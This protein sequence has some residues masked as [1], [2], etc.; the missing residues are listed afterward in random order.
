MDVLEDWVCSLTQTD[1]VRF[2]ELNPSLRG[3]VDAARL[4]TFFTNYICREDTQFKD[5]SKTFA[6]IATDLETGREIWFT[7]GLVLNAV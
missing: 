7:K 5:L 2:F 3:F 4:Q 1:M 6:T